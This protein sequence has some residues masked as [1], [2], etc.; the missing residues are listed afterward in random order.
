M[1]KTI[2]SNILLFTPSG[3][4]MAPV[5][6]TYDDNEPIP[7][8]KSEITLLYNGVEYKGIGSDDFY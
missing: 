4:V 5:K 1:K 8:P 7:N 6:I 3:K 2:Q